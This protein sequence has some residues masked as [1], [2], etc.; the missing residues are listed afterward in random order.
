MSSAK[1]ISFPARELLALARDLFQ[2]SDLLSIINQVGRRIPELLTPTSALVIANVEGAD[3]AAAFNHRGAVTPIHHAQ[4]LYDVVRSTASDEGRIVLRRIPLAGAARM[5]GEGSVISVSFPLEN[6]WGALAAL[7]HP[8]LDEERLR[9]CEEILARLAELTGAAMSNVVSKMILEE[10]ASALEEVSK[11]A[12]EQLVSELRERELEVRE[13]HRV[14]MTDVLTGM[15]N[16]RGFYERAEQGL[17]MAR[18]Q[19]VE[20]AIIFADL[21]GLKTIN[22]RYGHCAGDVCLRSAARILQESFRDSDVIA[23]LGGDEFAAFTVDTTN[24]DV[25]VQRI[26]KRAAELFSEGEFPHPISFSIG[27]AVCDPASDQPLEEFVSMAD[28]AMYEAKRGRK[29][30]HQ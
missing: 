25:I 15:L 18:R 24:T 29:H 5:G 28:S 2:A 30:R 3:L 27:V 6:P 7:W 10:R 20:C 9:V 12:T 22:D 16:R 19:G 23:R 13:K 26:E 8:A 14:A 11:S 21:D 1:L 17:R 4:E